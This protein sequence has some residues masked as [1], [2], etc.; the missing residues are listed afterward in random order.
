P[1]MPAFNRS[2]IRTALTLFTVFIIISAQLVRIQ[3]VE[4]D[5]TSQR[6]AIAA[7]GE[8]IGNPRL[9]NAQLAVQR[10]EILDRNG[11]LI[12]GTEQDGDIYLR[13]YPDPAT[14]NVAG[15]YSPLLYGSAGLEATY[16]DV[17]TGRSAN[18]PI[19]RVVN[20]LLNRPQQ[21]SNLVLTLDSGLQQQAMDLLAGRPGAVV[22][23]DV[24]TGAVLVLA[25]GVTYDPN[26]LFTSTTD[27]NDAATLY[28]QSL[29]DSG[30]NPLVQRANLGLYTPG[31][32]FK[33]VTAAAGIELGVI[34]PEDV[35]E[36]DGD[37]TIDGRVL[38][39]N[40]RPDDSQTL[41]TVLEALA[42]SLNVVFA[43]IGL[44]IGAAGYWETVESFGISDR[45]PFDL[46]VAAGQLASSEEALE[47]DN[48]LADSAFGQGEIQVTPL[49]M[50]MVAAMYANDGDMMVPYLVGSIQS[51]E[52]D[53][54]D[55]TTPRVWRDPISAQTADTLQEMMINAVRNGAV[56][57]AAIDGYVVGGK[58]GTAETGDGG[59]HQWFIGF[60]GDGEPQF[61]VSVVLENADSGLGSAVN[62]GR[63]MLL[64]TMLTIPTN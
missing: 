36:D 8:T 43:Q 62:I 18:D 55:E 25:S 15:Y 24:E 51:P 57:G 29:G 1:R 22:V 49:Y 21:G 60:I 35:F 3:M 28:W 23:M 2:L 33:T 16:D 38:V 27:Q 52:G 4:R 64:A 37:I 56:S 42:W 61:A 40:N 14:A 7:D 6:T 41:W 11:H 17:L 30:L 54:L 5:D 20:D 50:C 58:T 39:E 19:D 26:R 45:I 47:D 10:G 31:S 63:E 12:A 44:L 34:S 46:P 9:A 48:L 32:T 13:T 59:T 53:L